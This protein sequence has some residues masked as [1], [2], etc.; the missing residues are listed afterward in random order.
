M[1]NE[2]TLAELVDTAQYAWEN[3]TIRH[4]VNLA[5]TMP[6]CVEEVI[7]HE[8]WHTSYCRIDGL[9]GFYRQKKSGACTVF[10]ILLNGDCTFFTLPPIVTHKFSFHLLLP[11]S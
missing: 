4:F 9:G 3:L 2:A 11:A 7:R 1:P 6:H 8:G 5:E 10:Q